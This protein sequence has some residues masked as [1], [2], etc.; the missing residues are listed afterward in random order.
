MKSRRTWS[1]IAIAALAVSPLVACSSGDSSNAAS[2]PGGK[3]TLEMW[4]FAD[5]PKDMVAEYQKLHPEITVTSKIG[6]YDAAHQSLLTALAAGRGPDIAQIAIDYMGEF[7]ATPG[8]FTDLKKFG[9]EDL[10]KD[11]LDWRWN[12]GVASSGE[13]VGIPTDVGGMAVAYRTDLFKQAGLPTEPAAVSA[14]WPTWDDYIA[15][16]KKYVAASGKKFIDSGKAVFRAESNQGDLKYVDAQGNTVYESNPQIKTAWDDGAAA[17]EGGLSANVATYTPQWNAAL[18]N[19]AISTLIAPAWMLGQIEQQAPGTKGKWNIAALPG[20]AGN[21]GGSFL[22]VPKNAPHAKEAYEFI[23]WLEAPAQQLTAFKRYQAFP[24]VP[25]LYTDPAVTGLTN[26]FFGAAKIGQIYVDSVK[27]VKPHP[28]G[29]KDRA[30]E[31]RFENGI[32]RVDQG[33]QKPDAAWDQTLSEIKR[34]LQ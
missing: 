28:V 8:A 11:Y 19:G 21:D 1:G 23:K 22:A 26:P 17:I 20:G 18:A 7:V 33:K 16:G 27:A 14:L 3:V 24:A 30:I 4:G 15:T 31:N 5:L 9:A 29:P 6:D 25:A 12:G 10:K 32:G 2:S 13:V 34:E